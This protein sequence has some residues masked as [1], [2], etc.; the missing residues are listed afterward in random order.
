MTTVRRERERERERE[1]HRRTDGEREREGE[2]KIEKR[3]EDLSF[4]ETE[5]QASSGSPIDVPQGTTFHLGRET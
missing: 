1:I 5:I 4:Q 3:E 2:R